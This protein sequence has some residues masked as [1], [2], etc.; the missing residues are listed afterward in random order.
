MKKTRLWWFLFIVFLT[1]C[2][3][4]PTSQTEFEFTFE[5]VNEQVYITGYVGKIPKNITLPAKYGSN[6]VYGIKKDA[7]R[8]AKVEKV[9]IPASIEVI[10]SGAFY[11]AKLNEVTFSDN[12]KLKTIQSYAFAYTKLIEIEIPSTVVSFGDYAFTHSTLEEVIFKQN[13]QL[14]TI[15]KYAFY[16]NVM[17]NFM[18]L[19]NTVVTIDDYAFYAAFKLTFITIPASVTKIGV[20]AFGFTRLLNRIVVDEN[21]PNYQDVRGVLLS[22][23]GVRLIHY[24]SNHL[25]RK[26]TL[27]DSVV[28][29]EDRA[30]MGSRIEQI[31]FTPQTRLRTIGKMAFKQTRL[32]GNLHIPQGVTAIY[33][34]A[35]YTKDIKSAFVPNS[36][37]YIGDNAFEKFYIQNI[38]LAFEENSINKTNALNFVI[39]NVF[40]QATYGETAQ[41][42]YIKFPTEVYVYEY[43]QTPVTYD[44]TIPDDI[45]GLPVKRIMS[46]AFMNSFITK[47]TIGVH[48]EVIHSRAFLNAEK[49]QDVIFVPGSEMRSI[50]GFS[51][52]GTD[53]LDEVVLPEGLT[54]IQFGAFMSTG[55]E[56]IY[57]PS[58]VNNVAMNVFLDNPTL[59]IYT[60]HIAL[61]ATWDPA[62]NPDNVPIIYNTTP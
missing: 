4:V 46:S 62:F 55:L 29:I 38:F 17:L 14:R 5:T 54:T 33:E 8:L 41:F 34:E 49:L 20:D 61:P 53:A 30:F 45:E 48:V 58:S 44:V 35:F 27:P 3:A 18:E 12:A 7:F 56:Y 10:E 9:T 21:N 24:P 42:S 25:E 51:F 60:A 11:A 36:V 23:D 47:V 2:Q 39:G 52:Y 59:T 57:I 16:N 22:K 6:P 19:P 50:N 15:G 1:G 32:K 31:T 40:Y 26:Y 43:I 37:T 28:V 13:S